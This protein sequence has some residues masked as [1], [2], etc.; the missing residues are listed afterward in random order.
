MHQ[1]R[2]KEFLGDE[3]PVVC[4]DCGKILY[5]RKEAGYLINE[6]H[7]RHKMRRHTGKVPVRLYPCAFNP[8]FYHVTSKR[9]NPDDP[10]IKTSRKY[11]ENVA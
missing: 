4:G 1:L 2:L 8:G 5:S 9:F 3:N 11:I 6:M 7:G 10:I